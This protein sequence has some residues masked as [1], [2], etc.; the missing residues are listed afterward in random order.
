MINRVSKTKLRYCAIL[1]LATAWVPIW[2]QGPTDTDACRRAYSNADDQ[3][4]AL[5]FALCTSR[6][7]V[8]QRQAHGN[9][10]YRY[11][12]I[13]PD[14]TLYSVIRNRRIDGANSASVILTH[15]GL[16]RRDQGHQVGS[17][18]GYVE[19]TLVLQRPAFRDVKNEK[20]PENKIH[21]FSS[22]VCYQ[23]G[24]RMT[25]RAKP[26]R[27]DAQRYIYPT[28]FNYQTRSTTS[29]RAFMAEYPPMSDQNW[30]MDTFGHQPSSTTSID[31]TRMKVIRQHINA[32][33]ALRDYLQ[34]SWG[35]QFHTYNYDTETGF[36]GTLNEYEAWS[37]VRYPAAPL[38]GFKDYNP[39]TN[40]WPNVVTVEQ[41][42]DGRYVASGYPRMQFSFASGLDL[43]ENGDHHYNLSS[44]TTSTIRRFGQSPTARPL[45]LDDGILD[46]EQFVYPGDEGYRLKTP[47]LH[48]GIL[49]AETRLGIEG[50][51]A[52]D[53]G[54]HEAIDRHLAIIPRISGNPRRYIPE[55]TPIPSLAVGMRWR[56]WD[57]YTA[58]T[59][60]PI[61]WTTEKSKTG[62]TVRTRLGRDGTDEDAWMHEFFDEQPRPSLLGLYL[63]DRR[64]GIAQQR[65]AL[66]TVA[67]V[68][69][70]TGIAGPFNPFIYGVHRGDARYTPWMRDGDTTPDFRQL[71]NQVSLGDPES[72]LP[73]V[74]CALRMLEWPAGTAE[75][76]TN[77][78]RPE[79]YA[80]K[81][82]VNIDFSRVPITTGLPGNVVPRSDLLGSCADC[83][84]WYT[85][86]DRTWI[87]R[88]QDFSDWESFHHAI[89]GFS[90]RDHELLIAGD[91]LVP[92]E[93]WKNY[94]GPLSEAQVRAQAIEQYSAVDYVLAPQLKTWME[95]YERDNKGLDTSSQEARGIGLMLPI[96]TV[97]EVEYWARQLTS[98]PVADPMDRTGT[99]LDEMGVFRC[100][101]PLND[102]N[103]IG[104]PLPV[105][106]MGSTPQ[107]YLTMADLEGQ[108]HCGSLTL[109][110]SA[111]NPTS[112]LD[113]AEELQA[114]D[115]QV[116]VICVPI[117]VWMLA[118]NQSP[119]DSADAS[120]N[121]LPNVAI[122]GWIS[123]FRIHVFHNRQPIWERQGDLEPAYN[124][125][126]LFEDNVLN[127]EYEVNV[128]LYLHNMTLN[129]DAQTW[130]PNVP[131]CEGRNF[132]V[133]IQPHLTDAQ[134]GA[135]PDEEAR[136]TRISFTRFHMSL[137]TYERI[138]HTRVNYLH[139]NS[140]SVSLSAIRTQPFIES[141]YAIG[142][143][144]GTNP[145]F[146][147]LSRQTA[148]TVMRELGSGG[149][150]RGVS[151][152]Q[153]VCFYRSFKYLDEDVN[154]SSH[155]ELYEMDY[156]RFTY[157]P[158]GIQH[159][160]PN[161]AT[162]SRVI[163]AR[164]PVGTSHLRLIRT[165]NVPRG[166]RE[167]ETP[168]IIAQN[169]LEDNDN[170]IR[171]VV[172][173]D[174]DS[175]YSVNLGQNLPEFLWPNRTDVPRPDSELHYAGLGLGL[176]ARPG[177]IHTRNYPLASAMRHYS[178]V[179]GSEGVKQADML[180]YSRPTPADEAR[181]SIRH[182]GW[183]AGGFATQ[184]NHPESNGTPLPHRGIANDIRN[185]SFPSA[186][187]QSAPKSQPYGLPHGM[188]AFY[189]WRRYCGIDQSHALR[190]NAAR[191]NGIDFASQAHLEQPSYVND[192]ISPAISDDWSE[193]VGWSLN[194]DK[195]TEQTRTRY[196]S[197]Y[198]DSF[199]V[200]D[201]C[202]TV[203]NA[204]LDSSCGIFGYWH[205]VAETTQGTY[206]H[207]FPEEE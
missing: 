139:R 72:Q 174:P 49:I 100:V 91:H 202:A 138:F 121:F 162:P 4:L 65:L 24:S 192:A 199:K 155:P 94:T 133:A 165:P 16:E 142:G 10:L 146:G 54:M 36:N 117:P 79:F 35:S 188:E 48:E 205:S 44:E 25:I 18:E 81:E 104:E 20:D 57:G 89:P 180:D 149:T 101:G 63:G 90:V 185:L 19:P 129:P 144:Y 148:V 156:V 92:T 170:R 46:P 158:P 115:Q 62:Q 179:A 109:T 78:D 181:A 124:Y 175:V 150:Y 157:Q 131:P 152:E 3:S 96:G 122:P 99:L 31:D 47:H 143:Q 50:K 177:R 197:R 42:K 120:L 169:V 74:Q 13:R 167:L 9:G 134:V 123:M 154:P 130:D 75:V 166:S 85:G 12:A 128:E 64:T 171:W 127:G 80:R 140:A 29:P 28:Y 86:D 207:R 193:N 187:P 2:A 55:G 8:T 168:F 194:Q 176:L 195:L 196:L 161:R 39:I 204:G 116:T 37:R 15:G 84:A 191:S 102:P 87:T 136:R 183:W 40:R 164:N 27:N 206:R 113:V 82:F 5:D 93:Y 160:D 83:M 6:F 52:I 95:E 60:N 30:L 73:L 7:I 23:Y 77:K 105:D 22:Q 56:K 200:Q 107:R 151:G 1:L 119:E 201:Y 147:S 153:D 111:T 189:H 43:H 61:L 21:L 141:Q 203:R 182:G 68:L 51:N 172:E 11:G 103:A 135:L 59:R 67:E 145:D 137:D 108:A 98:V 184:H 125:Q 88:E 66:N 45:R 53:Y 32:S 106:S 97:G 41:D 118:P 58:T 112:L 173:G 34:S 38:D 33:E 70:E 132:N 159:S 114:Y 69:A 76:F 71:S 14:G 186:P 17:L 126:S 110:P 26:A 178:G 198:L 190:A 163:A